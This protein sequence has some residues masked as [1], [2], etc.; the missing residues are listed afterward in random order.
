M[1]KIQVLL[2]HILLMVFHTTVLAEYSKEY[3]DDLERDIKEKT[4]QLMSWENLVYNI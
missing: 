3:C 4:A 1:I 2:L